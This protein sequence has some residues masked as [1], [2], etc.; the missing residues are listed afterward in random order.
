MLTVSKV[1][2]W[3]VE[4]GRR[5]EENERSSSKPPVILQHD[6]APCARAELPRYHHRCCRVTPP[7]SPATKTLTFL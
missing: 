3:R 5:A 4:L 1:L 6:G 2:C 7:T